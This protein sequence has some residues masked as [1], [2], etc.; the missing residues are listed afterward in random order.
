MKEKLIKLRNQVLQ[1]IGDYM[2]FRIEN[3]RNHQE[4]EQ[5]LFIGLWFDDWCKEHN[6]YLL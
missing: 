6:Y 5:H 4:Y 3:A 2:F 1:H